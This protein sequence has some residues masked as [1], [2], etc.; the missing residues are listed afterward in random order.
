MSTSRGYPPSLSVSPWAL[1]P[2]Y[3][4]RRICRL[5]LLMKLRK[6]LA[7]SLGIH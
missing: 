3:D 1:A 2:R 5:L 6:P 7:L 4:I